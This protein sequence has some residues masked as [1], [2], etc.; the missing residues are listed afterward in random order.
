MLVHLHCFFL[1]M[2]LFLPCV[3]SAEVDNFEEDVIRCICGVSCDEGYMI[4]CEK[5]YVS[6]QHLSN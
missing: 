2:L 4:Q 1:A 3:G 5:C 6:W